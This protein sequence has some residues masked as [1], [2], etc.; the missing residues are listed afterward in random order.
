M[1]SQTYAESVIQVAGG[2][3]FQAA[4]AVTPSDSTTYTP[5]LAALYV[6]GTGGVTVVPASGGAAVLFA[7]VPAGTVL[8][9]ACSKVMAT[10]TSA[11]GIV[12]L[13]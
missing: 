10:G 4:Q 2:A 8:P 3:S 11:T 5:P 7:G 6:G 12:G 1:S 9:I 13:N